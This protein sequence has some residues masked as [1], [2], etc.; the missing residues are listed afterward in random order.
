V[1]RAHPTVPQ[2]QIPLWFQQRTDRP[3]LFARARY[4]RRIQMALRM[5]ALVRA[6]DDSWFARKGMGRSQGSPT[7]LTGRR[8]EDCPAKGPTRKTQWPRSARTPNEDI[9]DL[10]YWS[11]TR[12]KQGFALN[13]T[14]DQQ[15]TSTT[16][17][18]RHR[19]SHL[20]V[21]T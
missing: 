15:E 17:R 11:R 21:V 3:D 1:V 2:R 10:G 16:F 19:R 5:V 7:S 9:G 4:K 6:K 8:T 18:V 13:A 14:C 20:R 12:R